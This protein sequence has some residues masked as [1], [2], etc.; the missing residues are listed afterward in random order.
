MWTITFYAYSGY[1]FDTAPTLVQTGGDYSIFFITHDD[2]L[3]GNDRLV[4]RTYN[5]SCIVPNYSSLT[6][7]FDV[8]AVAAEIFVPVV[9]ITGYSLDTSVISIIGEIRTLTI[10]GSE[11]ANWTLTSPQYILQ[12]GPPDPITGI[13][14]Y[15]TTVSGVINST[16]IATLLISIDE[17]FVSLDYSI[18]L[19]GDLSVEFAQPNPIILHQY[20]DIAITYSVPATTYFTGNADKFNS[21]LP[22]SS[23]LIGMDGYSNAFDWEVTPLSGYGMILVQDPSIY[24]FDNLDPVF[25]GGTVLS[26][27]TL[28]ATQSSPALIS[29]ETTGQVSTYGINSMTTSLNLNMFIAYITTA[30]ITYITYNS[31]I[32]G[33]EVDYDGI[34]AAIGI[35]GLCYSTSPNPT[36]TDYLLPDTATFGAFTSNMTGLS[37]LTTYYAR[38]YA[39]NESG[40]VFY[41]NQQTFNTLA[42]TDELCVVDPGWTTTNASHTTYRDGSAI[43]DGSALSNAA[44]NALT[45]GAWCYYN[46]DPLNGPIYGKLYNWYAVV[47]IHDAASLTDP[48]LRKEFAPLDYKVPTDADWTTLT[49]CLGGLAIAGGKMKEAGTAHWDSPNTEATNISGFTALPGGNRD[50]SGAFS[51]LGAMGIYLSS[52]EFPI[53]PYVYVR[54]FLSSS[55]SAGSNYSDKYRGESVRLISTI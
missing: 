35:K 11:G 42:N 18:L 28:T 20:T 46:N 30:P 23:P 36:I 44:W 5:I 3:D 29:I 54:T 2:V 37:P 15:G 10:F 32:S 47:G 51:G 45:I 17:S 21:G 43:L 25:N 33:G 49:T 13:I 12:T 26:I 31:A 52:T 24:G 48:L 27:N 1:Y 16:G 55:G 8:Q 9:E 6:N 41:G 40:D 53:P 39:Y 19:S 34:S 38:A 14:P 22:F 4:E 7:L 50:N